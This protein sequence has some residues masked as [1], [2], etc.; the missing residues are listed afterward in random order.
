M[1]T[2]SRYTVEGR[3]FTWTTEDGD[4]VTIPL[5]IRLGMIRQ[6]THKALDAD[7]MFEIL[8]DLIPDQAEVL[9]NM[10]LND[11]Q[12]MFAAWQRE[13]QALAGASLGE[14]SGSST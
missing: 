11:F 1:T 10:D 7:T 12:S 9:D 2:D 4:T 14:S 6:I 3:T 8:D 13:Y 5:R